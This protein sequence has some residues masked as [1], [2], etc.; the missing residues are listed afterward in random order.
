M[1][2]VTLHH[3][4]QHP[5]DV[6]AI[7]DIEELCMRKGVRLIQK[8]DKTANE[9]L[10]PYLS[11]GSYK[12]NYPFSITEFE[13]ILDFVRV[14]SAGKILANP[15][16]I[17]SSSKS[18][19]VYRNYVWLISGFFLLFIGIPFLAPI[20]MHS[21]KERA[22]RSIYKVYSVLCHQLAFRSYFLFG[23]QSQYPRQIAQ[24]PGFL[25]YEQA[26][27]K[28]AFD[29]E[30]ARRFEGS[31]ELGYKVAI[32]ERDIA[33]YGS[34]ALF[35]VVFQITRR[36]IKAIPW[37]IWVIVALIPIAIDG[38]SQLPGLASGWPTWLP[39][40]ESTFVLRTITG[41]LFGLF[42]AW[43]LFPHMEETLKVSQ[44]LRKD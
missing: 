25:T 28:D 29:L 8:I 33:I 20:L 39:Q 40:R 15:G 4:K 9:E 19:W 44:A 42:T 27:G 2:E 18:S 5:I 38:G 32:C 26:T 10:L 23:S 17:P 41:T 22:A 3:S 24:V 14:Q 35:G 30:Y 16:I 21:G 6:N 31:P 7:H 34:M 12:L 36:K 43:F 1:P 13:R 11:I 37:Y